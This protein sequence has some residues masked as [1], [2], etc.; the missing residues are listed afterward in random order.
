MLNED[1]GTSQPTPT[2]MDAS[3]QNVN[4]DSSRIR[5]SRT[6]ELSHPNS[7]PN[8]TSE[9]AR[10][11]GAEAEQKHRNCDELLSWLQTLIGELVDRGIE[12]KLF[13]N[14]DMLKVG[15]KDVYY[16]TPHKMIHAGPTCPICR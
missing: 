3:G 1:C 12:V 14:G 13:Q 9:E 5:Q 15:L 6:S 16:C 8:S 4:S 11:D 2:G 10:A 7:P